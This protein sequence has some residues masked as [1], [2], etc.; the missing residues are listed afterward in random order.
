VLPTDVAVTLQDLFERRRCAFQA[1]KKA[2]AVVVALKSGRDPAGQ[3]LAAA[4]QERESAGVARTAAYYQPLVEREA[5]L[6]KAGKAKVQFDDVLE[7]VRAAGISYNQIARHLGVWCSAVEKWY[8]GIGRPPH[9]QSNITIM[10]DRTSGGRS[11]EVAMNLEAIRASL[12]SLQKLYESYRS[13]TAQ[14]EAL[15]RESRSVRYSGHPIA[16]RVRVAGVEFRDAMAAYKVAAGHA[17]A[18]LRIAKRDALDA[19]IAFGDACVR[20][21]QARPTDAAILEIADTAGCSARLIYHLIDID[22]FANCEHTE[23]AE[24]CGRLEAGESIRDLA[25]EYHISPQN[26]QGLFVVWRGAQHRE[27]VLS[28]AAGS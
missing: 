25:I 19:D 5:V 23:H 11:P 26:I 14:G 28:A 18:A 10:L 27:V 1:L 20:A 16:R 9:V 15:W 21:Y 13:L 8:R 4:K 17:R 22:P 3:R 6:S 12:D 2:R 7:Q 24:I